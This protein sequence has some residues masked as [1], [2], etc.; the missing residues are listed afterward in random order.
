MKVKAREMRQKK[1]DLECL[2]RLVDT[3]LQKISIDIV[4]LKQGKSAVDSGL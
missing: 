4:K 1:K 3:G 2:E